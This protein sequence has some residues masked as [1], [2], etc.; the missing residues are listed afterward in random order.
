MTDRPNSDQTP[1]PRPAGTGS[2]QFR[3]L[4]PAADRGLIEQACYENFNWTGIERFTRAQIAAHP[5]M[6]HYTE[7]GPRDFGL[8]AVDGSVPLGGSCGASTPTRPTPGYGF[9]AIDAPELNICVFVDHRGR[10][11]GTA[12]LGEIVAVATERGGWPGSA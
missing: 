10:G 1:P 6:G 12:L 5:I 2:V 3:A 9:V 8:V 4:D 11:I 7:F